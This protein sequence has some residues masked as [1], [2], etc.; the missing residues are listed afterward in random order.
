MSLAET[1]PKPTLR[2]LQ[3][4]IG[5]KT[6]S[7]LVTLRESRQYLVWALER[8]AVWEDCFTDAAELL[9]KLAESENAKH[10]NN[11]TGTFKGLF[12]LIPGAAATQAQRRNG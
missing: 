5:S 6:E 7:Q 4:I 8:L 3:R 1:T 9:A 12:C 11:A 10:S 2:A